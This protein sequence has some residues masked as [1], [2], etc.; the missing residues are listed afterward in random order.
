MPGRQLSKQC[1]VS[2]TESEQQY[3][4]KS[5]QTDPFSLLPRRKSTQRGNK[6]PFM[7]MY[8]VNYLKLWIRG[9]WVALTVWPLSYMQL[10]CHDV[11]VDGLF[12]HVFALRWVTRET[13]SP[14]KTNTFDQIPPGFQKTHFSMTSHILFVHIQPL[15]PIPTLLPPV[16][17]P[18]MKTCL[19][20]PILSPRLLTVLMF[21][22]SAES[23]QA[24]SSADLIP[25][26]E[27]KRHWVGR[28]TTHTHT[29]THIVT[30][31]WNSQELDQHSYALFF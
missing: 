21:K 8:Q 18:C 3:N 4:G 2:R 14:L 9:H 23:R 7:C 19:A 31:E 5:V 25:C 10:F 11:D 26:W 12:V 6:K 30:W 1:P 13:L 17:Y 27:T 22:A 20:I 29:H 28:V 15:C 24:Q 16:K